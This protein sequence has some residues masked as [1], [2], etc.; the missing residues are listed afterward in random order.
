[1][2]GEKHN[3][4]IKMAQEIGD[5]LESE[6]P[7]IQTGDDPDDQTC[8][9]I[10]GEHVD[11]I[12]DYITLVV[13]QILQGWLNAGSERDVTIEELTDPIREHVKGWAK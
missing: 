13:A 4:V 8:R 7:A 9:M 10:P 6:F 12:S 2:N 11:E 3:R 5:I 1:M